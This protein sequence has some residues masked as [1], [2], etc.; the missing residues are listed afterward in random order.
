[1][2]PLSMQRRTC[3]GKSSLYAHTYSPMD[4]MIEFLPV[5]LLFLG[6]L[7]NAREC[8]FNVTV[9]KVEE[10]IFNKTNYEKQCEGILSNYGDSVTMCNGYFLNPKCICSYYMYVWEIK[11]ICDTSDPKKNGSLEHTTIG[12]CKKYSHSKN[13]PCQNNGNL[14]AEY[15]GDDALADDAICVCEKDY[16]GDYCDVYNG[17]IKCKEIEPGNLS[18]LPD[19]REQFR[20]RYC[21]LTVNHNIK[22]MCDSEDIV[23]GNLDDCLS[24]PSSEFDSQSGKSNSQ[25]TNRAVLTGIVFLVSVEFM[26]LLID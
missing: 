23:Q 8:S 7:T 12:F 1:M 13:G 4:V 17:T 24:I 15:K 21:L 20:S 6:S 2:V 9:I 19:C 22:L 5:L 26:N 3:D 10:Q 18:S 11:D 14:T 25:S 16:S